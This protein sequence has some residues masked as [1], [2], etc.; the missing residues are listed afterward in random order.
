DPLLCT[1]KDGSVFAYPMMG[2]ARLR[3]VGFRGTVSAAMIY[4]DHAVIDYFRKVADDV[5]LGVMD[6]K[7]HPVDFYFHLT[8]L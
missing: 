1:A 7:G 6:P 3:E 2:S 4:D 8:R 5:V